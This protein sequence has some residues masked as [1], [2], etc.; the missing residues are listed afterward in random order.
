MEKVVRRS[1]LGLRQCNTNSN[2]DFRFCAGLG[3]CDFG[4][5]VDSL[6]WLARVF[7]C[8]LIRLVLARWSIGK[9]SNRHG[10]PLCRNYS[11]RLYGGAMPSLVKCFNPH[12][13]VWSGDAYPQQFSQMRTIV[14]IRARP[15]GRA[16]RYWPGRQVQHLHSFNPRPTAWSGDAAIK[17]IQSHYIFVS[18]RARP[19][20]RAMRRLYN[21][22]LLYK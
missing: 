11:K 7:R 10:I 8:G 21:M 18:I 5:G 20:G 19:L 9:D 13:T 14:S 3:G 4:V 17:P 15:L 12:L 2:R 6:S 16:M 1:D 22:T